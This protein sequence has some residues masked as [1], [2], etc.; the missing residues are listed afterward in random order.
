M[1]P[2]KINGGS[3]F[4]AN[5]AM[6]WKL[7][8]RPQLTKSSASIS[9]AAT[10]SKKAKYVNGSIL[11]RPKLEPS[12][13]RFS[14]WLPAFD[15]DNFHGVM[16]RDASVISLVYLASIAKGVKS[17]PYYPLLSM[18]Q[19]QDSHSDA[20]RQDPAETSYH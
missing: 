3:E 12:D 1:A 2:E 19:L 7:E 15:L 9:I 14:G 18:L 8:W 16:Q 10:Y 20:V 5:H 13:K 6:M 4:V 17:Q 11:P